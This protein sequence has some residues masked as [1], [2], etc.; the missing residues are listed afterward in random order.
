M[1]GDGP[2]RR[3]NAAVS[4]RRSRW[5][6]VIAVAFTVVAL[7]AIGQ[8]P[9]DDGV[10]TT[11]P[12]ADATGTPAASGSASPPADTAEPGLGAGP[13]G[14]IE[15]ATV[16]RVVDGDTIVVDRGLGDERVRYIGIDTPETVDPRQE[17]QWM[18]PEA[19]AAN[20]ALV[21]GREVVLER[22]VSETDRFGRLLRYVW[23]EDG[24]A[25]GAAPGWLLV[26]LALVARGFAQVSTFPPD[27]RYVDLYLEA[28]RQARDAGLG[29][30]G[31]PPE[32]TDETRGG[33]DDD[34]DPAYSGVCIPPP[35]PDL[36]CGDVPFRNFE[37]KPPDPHRFDGDADGLGC[38]S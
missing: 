28:Q 23:L 26:N 13:I 7:S 34:C 31:E 6:L 4:D 2:G 22:D 8:G 20:K 30:W 21:A 15:R 5:W 27:V 29:L 16:V 38:E 19:S 35:P 11:D 25:A 12:V 1:T 3:T 17:V 14:P 32:P 10:R 9:G 37:V 24:S 33:N 18:G 36:D